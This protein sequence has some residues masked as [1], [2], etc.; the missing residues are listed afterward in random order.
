MI[1]KEKTLILKNGKTCLLRSPQAKDAELLLTY[2]QTIASETI[3]LLRYPDDILPS[4][5]EELSFIQN[6]Q[7]SPDQLMIC[8]FVGDELAGT[9]SLRLHNKIKTKHRA[10]I[11]IALLQ[12]FWGLGL[13]SKLLDCLMDAAKNKGCE[14]IELE[15][16]QG[17]D[18]AI[19]L[20]EKKGFVRFAERK[21]GIRLKDGSYLSEYLMKKDLAAD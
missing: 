10:E 16:I 2:L 4:M 11:G 7:K 17:N 15:V 5:E 21:R 3:F 1:F 18:R 8:A 6:T 12:K 9:A 14:L 20:Y 19:T 13:G